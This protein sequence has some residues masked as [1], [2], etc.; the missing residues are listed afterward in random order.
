[1]YS[2]RTSHLGISR[3][4]TR[5]VQLGYS[6]YLS[7][8]NPLIVRQ[9]EVLMR[10][11]EAPRN[12]QLAIALFFGSGANLERDAINI[13]GKD[14]FD[15]LLDAKILRSQEGLCA[16]NGLIL[17]PTL[18]SWIFCQRPQLNPTLYLGD[19]SL[20][21]ASHLFPKRGARCLDFCAGP[22]I[23]SLLLS[24]F[25]Q[26]VVSVE[27]NP[28]A[29]AL[30]SLNAVLNS[31]ENVMQVRCG[32]LYGALGDDELFDYVVANPP[33][34]PFPEGVA[35][36]FVGHGGNDG[37]RVTWR[38][39]ESL[40]SHLASNGVAKIVQALLCDGVMPLCVDRL[41]SFAKKYGLDILLSVVSR[42]KLS[43]ESRYFNGLVAT[44]V[45]AMGESEARVRSEFLGL[46][47]RESATHI[48]FAYIMTQ[49][50]NGSLSIQDL[51]MSE[52]ASWFAN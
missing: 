35:Y 41:E 23:Q 1:M 14:L 20:G 44:S 49:H 17:F 29:A 25:A 21:L 7:S 45:G 42:C 51:T 24:R 37:M 18:G 15:S 33:L 36:P 5:L 28:V 38:I 2:D 10:V 8:F 6:E 48:C 27:I 30:A 34:L 43:T 11:H 52:R 50:G 46:L 40:P 12:L 31:V 9:S 4:P 39:L 47:Q 13:L 32:D 3:L 22:G 26:K 16:T 19:D